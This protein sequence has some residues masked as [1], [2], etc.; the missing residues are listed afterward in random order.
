MMAKNSPGN[1]SPIRRNNNDG[2]PDRAHDFPVRVPRSPQTVSSE[3]PAS[4]EP[5]VFKE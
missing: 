5:M 4:N 1:K 2:W 3:C